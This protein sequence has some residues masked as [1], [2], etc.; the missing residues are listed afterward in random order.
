MDSN[1]EKHISDL[2]ANLVKLKAEYV[3]FNDR[4]ISDLSD[5]EDKSNQLLAMSGKPL[6]KDLQQVKGR[7]YPKWYVVEIPFSNGD[8][9]PKSGSVEVAGRPFIC[10]QMQAL[11]LITDTDV[12]H[13][14][15]YFDTGIHPMSVYNDVDLPA[16]G[17]S[18]P[19]TA[20]FATLSTIQYAYTLL[21]SN[22]EVATI[23]PDTPPYLKYLFS[24]LNNLIDPFG[25]NRRFVGWSYPDFDFEIRNA[26]SGRRWTDSKVPA[27][28]FY[29]ATGNP[30][31]LSHSGFFDGYDRIEVTAHP[32]DRPSG[33][34]SI[35]LDG[36]VKFVFFGYE[37]D[38]DVILSDVFGY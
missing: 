35:N 13:Y 22:P 38:T 7:R 34:S 17:R 28:A 30:L 3:A 6:L 21:A 14:P 16:N 1:I 5:L 26:N 10:T 4:K 19:T 15:S 9:K 36:I 23:S 25:N 33:V 24:E 29:S 18:Y 12:T 2:T 37:I 31:F 11:Y 27:A 8:T 32:T 20:Y